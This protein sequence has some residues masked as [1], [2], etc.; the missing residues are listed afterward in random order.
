[1][2]NFE[3]NN[4]PYKNGREKKEEKTE[5]QHGKLCT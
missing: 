3:Q 2:Y 4:F 5:N 1:M